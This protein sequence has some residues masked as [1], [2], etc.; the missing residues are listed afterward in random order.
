M[1]D[2]MDNTT[3][4]NTYLTKQIIYTPNTVTKRGKSSIKLASK[5]EAKK[6]VV[7]DKWSIQSSLLEHPP[8]LEIIHNALSHDL[9][10][11]PLIPLFKQQIESKL[12]GYKQQDIK[13]RL[14][15]EAKFITFDQ[16]IVM[17][18]A[19][20]L[21]C[22]Y[23]NVTVFVLY[24]NVRDPRQWSLDRIDN[25]AGHNADNLLIACLKCNLKRRR[26]NM[27]SFMF[28]RKMKLVKVSTLP[29]TLP[30]RDKPVPPKWSKSSTLPVGAYEHPPPK[31]SKS[32]TESMTESM[33]ESL[34]ESMTESMTE[35]LTESMTESLTESM[36]ESLE[37]SMTESMTESLTESLTICKK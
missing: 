2:N 28:T 19:S 36:T 33:T 31:W 24:E 5:E 18:R 23:C 11:L 20:K 15:N 10:Y 8:Q 6:R 35:S 37:E 9:H 16:T 32:H 26:I 7:C 22:C 29:S 14:H 27:D 30:V 25:N 1:D 13:K 3:T 12:Y 17:L 4:D 34:T 21:V